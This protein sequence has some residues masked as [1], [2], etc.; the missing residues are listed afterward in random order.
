M[1]QALLDCSW[2]QLCDAMDVIMQSALALVSWRLAFALSVLRFHG[3]LVEEN[4][5]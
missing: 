1:K 2:F 3:D 5:P 4:Y